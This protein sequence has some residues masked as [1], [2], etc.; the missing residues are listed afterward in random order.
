MLTVYIREVLQS[1]TLNKLLITGVAECK[2][3]TQL[4]KRHI[5]RCEGSGS[6]EALGEG[7]GMGL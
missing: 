3:N 7:I 2:D 6:M 1:P 4:R 5:F